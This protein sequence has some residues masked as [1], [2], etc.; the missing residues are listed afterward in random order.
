MRSRPA[1]LSLSFYGLVLLHVR[2]PAPIITFLRSEWGQ[3]EVSSPNDT[4]DAVAIWGYQLRPEPIVGAEARTEQ[5]GGWYKGCFWRA[6]LVRDGKRM[7]VRYLSVPRS[8]LLF[9]DSCLEPIVLAQLR[10]RGLYAIHA[11]SIC[12]GARAWVFCGPPSSGKTM[13][14]LISTESGHTLLSDD[15]TIFGNGRIH[16]YLVPP[17]VYPYQR[18]DRVI[19][20]YLTRRWIFLES[21]RET[22][23]NFAALGGIR[24]PARIALAAKSPESI[25]AR[26]DYPIG[27]FFFLRRAGE[28]LH[29]DP[30]HDK[31]RLAVEVLGGPPVHGVSLITEK[32]REN[33]VSDERQASALSVIGELVDQKRCLDVTLPARMTMADWK[34]AST[35]LVNRAKEID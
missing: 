28:E 8:N 2:A 26:Q 32:L 25:P 35:E 21:I 18:G 16:A 29:I 20:N 24:L 33:S 6:L 12:V 34:R 19:Y 7:A 27:G 14:G 10:A 11:S 3:F 4:P 17:R 13:L 22:L 5:L 1:E 30:V 23:T 15:I 31:A 9:K